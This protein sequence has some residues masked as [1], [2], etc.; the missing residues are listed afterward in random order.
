MR[1]NWIWP[2]VSYKAVARKAV[3]EGVAACGFIAVV[4]LGVAAYAMTSHQTFRGYGAPVLV[5]G[6]VFALI[7]FWLWRNSRIASVLAVSVMLLEVADKLL[8]H[9][10]TFNIVTLILLLAI[11]NSVRGAF[12]LHRNDT[13]ESTLAASPNIRPIG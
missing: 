2:N 6:I 12:A 1:N 11:V 5:D 13:P 8:H 4:D 7:G 3:Q 9:A 10:A